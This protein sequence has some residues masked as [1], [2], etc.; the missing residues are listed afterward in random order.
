M[1]HSNENKI[2]REV[3]EHYRRLDTVIETGKHNGWEIGDKNWWEE[4]NRTMIG[5]PI[6]ESIRNK[7]YEEVYAETSIGL[8]ELFESTR[9]YRENN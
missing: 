5:D 1:K 7:T 3:N 2:K 9:K 6:T 4:Y 8:E